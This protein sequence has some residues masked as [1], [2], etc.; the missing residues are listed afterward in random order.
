[1]TNR[2]KLI[3]IQGALNAAQKYVSEL[4]GEQT[5][6]AAPVSQ[7]APG[8]NTGVTFPSD[9][10][11]KT[12]ADMITSKQLGM[13]RALARETGQDVD[14]ECSRLM[15]CT[16]TELS[17]RGASALIDHFNVIKNN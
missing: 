10:I 8:H 6:N 7:R 9:P 5:N 11:A 14:D 16:V 15:N 4:L 17:R 2:E 1:M 12:L 13:I 3:N